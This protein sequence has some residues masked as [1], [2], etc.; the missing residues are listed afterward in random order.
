MECK[1]KVKAWMSIPLGPPRDTL[2]I[3]MDSPKFLHIQFWFFLMVFKEQVDELYDEGVDE[4]SFGTPQL[5]GCS[6]T[7]WKLLWI[8]LSSCIFNF[9]SF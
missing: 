9:G 4:C 3:T 6:G 7:P 5:Q 1:G 8:P 2:E